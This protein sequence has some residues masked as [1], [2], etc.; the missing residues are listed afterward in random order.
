MPAADALMRFTDL[1]VRQEYQKASPWES[2]GWVRDLSSTM[3]NQ[4][5]R[6]FINNDTASAAGRRVVSDNDYVAGGLAADTWQAPAPVVVSKNVLT[7]DN[8]VQIRVHIPSAIRDASQ[9][10]FARSQAVVQGRQYAYDVNA[11]LQAKMQALPNTRRIGTVTVAAGDWGNEKHQEDLVAQIRR[12]RRRM[13]T[14]GV[15]QLR[16]MPVHSEDYDVIIDWALRHNFHFDGPIND[17]L[18]R[19][20]MIPDFF[21]FVIAPMDDLA[22]GHANTDDIR[23]RIYAFE[24]RIGISMAT[25]RDGMRTW[26]GN[27]PQYRGIIMD[28]AYDFGSVVDEPGKVYWIQTTIT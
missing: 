27:H 15:G 2:M 1:I 17:D 8:H 16:I 12:L 22:E 25:Q 13:N 20:G 7:K 3:R 6:E 19:R 26:D 11:D 4:R 18:V 5:T 9:V 21:G 10:D 14:D 23:H 28:D 24:P